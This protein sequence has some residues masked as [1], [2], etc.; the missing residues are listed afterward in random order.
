[1]HDLLRSAKQEIE[2][3]WSDVP[4]GKHIKTYEE[5]L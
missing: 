1:M 4:E 3:L 5:A 2:N